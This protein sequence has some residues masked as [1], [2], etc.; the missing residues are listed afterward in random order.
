MGAEILIDYV[1]STAAM[2]IP[3]FFLVVILSK[4]LSSPEK[5]NSMMGRLVACQSAMVVIGFLC[6][7]LM[8]PIFLLSSASQRTQRMVLVAAIEFFYFSSLAWLNVLCLETFYN[9]RGFKYMVIN[10]AESKGKRL[11]IYVIHTT[12]VSV[13][14][15][16]LAELI[17]K[18]ED[19]PTRGMVIVGNG[20]PAL[21]ISFCNGFLFV[22]TL[23]NLLTTRSEYEELQNGKSL[24]GVLQ[25]TPINMIKWMI[26]V[27]EVSVIILILAIMLDTS[28][29]LIL[30]LILM[31]Q[32]FWGVIY[33]CLTNKN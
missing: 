28:L 29:A 19:P 13:I 31:R 23:K 12:L 24:N 4:I 20:V 9:F 32:F 22:S 27:S 5:R 33:L 10:L 1:I 14:C 26:C 2:S 15:T 6:V 11:L 3:A 30:F 25:L 8:I 17:Q 16:F 18:A 7:L 21:I